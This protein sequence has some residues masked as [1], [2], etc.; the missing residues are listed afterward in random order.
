LGEKKK[1]RKKA[2]ILGYWFLLYQFC[3]VDEVIIIHKK[4]I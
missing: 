3:D 1:K 2:L 4:N